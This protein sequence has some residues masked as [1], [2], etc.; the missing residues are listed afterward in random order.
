MRSKWVVI[1]VLAALVATL[2]V[3]AGCGSKK[4]TTP[5]TT[6]KTTPSTTPSSG[7]TGS[8]VVIKNF[9]FEPSQLT[10]KAG[11]TVTWKNEDSTVHTVT[12][13]GWDSGQVQPGAEF[14]KTFDAAGTYDYSCSIHPSMTGKVVVN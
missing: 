10:V 14:Q 3:A 12:G 2:A 6:P 5:K 4:T 9:T 11:T 1:L 13:S 8:T 7:S